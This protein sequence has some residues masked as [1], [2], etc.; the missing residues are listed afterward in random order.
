MAAWAPDDNDQMPSNQ[1]LCGDPGLAQLAFFMEMEEE[2]AGAVGCFA[3][4][5]VRGHSQIDPRDVDAD[6]AGP[7]TASL[8]MD[9]PPRTLEAGA[10]Q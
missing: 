3:L 5:D 6:P 2:D 1:R 10:C 4:A 7:T 9:L 8:V